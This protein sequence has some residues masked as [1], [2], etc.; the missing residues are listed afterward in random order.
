MWVGTL[1]K[2]DI[3]TEYIYVAIGKSKRTNKDR[4]FEHWT[5]KEQAYECLPNLKANTKD[6]ILR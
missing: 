2:R 6:M 4:I 1:P 3:C 5:N